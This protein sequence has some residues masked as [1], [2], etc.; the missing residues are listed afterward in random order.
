MSEPLLLLESDGDVATLTFND[1]ERRNAMSQAMGEAFAARVA[2]LSRTDAFGAIIL[3]GAGRAFS[4]G[5]D[6]GMIEERLACPPFFRV[7]RSAILNLGWVDHLAPMFSG[8]FCATLKAP[9][10]M[11]IHV[12]R[13]RARELRRYLGW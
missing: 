1:P 13:R 9:V 2:E 4:A 6:L 11:E 10:K 8:T 12:S 5:G 7:S 3:T